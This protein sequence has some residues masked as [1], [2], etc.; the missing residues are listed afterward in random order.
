MME[1][2]SFQIVLK[3]LTIEF[4]FIFTYAIIGFIYV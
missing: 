2:E 1:N 4:N 3:T